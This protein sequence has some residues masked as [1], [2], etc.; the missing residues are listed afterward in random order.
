MTTRRHILLAARLLAAT[1]AASLAGQGPAAAQSAGRSWRV[2][3]GEVRVICPMTVGG[4]FEARTTA[5]EGTLSTAQSTTVLDGE[6]SVDLATLDTGIA[7]RNQHMRENYLE[8]HRGD[9]FDRAVLSRVDV[10]ALDAGV[11]G[12][13]RTFSGQLRLHGVVRAVAGRATLRSS[14]DG[15]RV[16]AS[17]PV[18]IPDYAIATPRY[19][20]VGV[21]DEVTI[22]VTFV[23][24]P[25]P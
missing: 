20:G 9:G 7:L 10:G 19:L 11:P 18:R 16:D 13:S 6:L 22:R 24:A 5:I 4:S 25:L 21:R 8:I 23:A 14:R 12:G 3:M 2:T 17:F 15:V 1:V